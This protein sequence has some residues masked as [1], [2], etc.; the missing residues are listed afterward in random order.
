[1]DDMTQSGS[2][3]AR[4]ADGEPEIEEPGEISLMGVVEVRARLGVT[5]GEFGS[6]SLDASFPEPVADLDSGRIWLTEDVEA[7]ISTHFR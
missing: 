7:W 5:T 4:D 2:K 3:L 1:M 6:L